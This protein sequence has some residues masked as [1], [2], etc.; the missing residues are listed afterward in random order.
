MDPFCGSGSTLVAAELL[1][2][3]GYGMEIDPAY[4][5]VIVSRLEAST[6]NPAHLLGTNVVV[7]PVQPAARN[8][9]SNAR[10]ASVC[11]LG[12]TWE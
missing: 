11:M 8:S 9:S 6:G 3:K 12:R 7:S 10:A 5:D 1:R 2:L 4:C